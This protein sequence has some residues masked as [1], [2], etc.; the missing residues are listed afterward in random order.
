MDLTDEWTI[1]EPW[2]EEQRRPDGR[3]RPWRDAR[4]VPAER[5]SWESSRLRPPLRRSAWSDDRCARSEQ[6]LP[7]RP[8]HGG[9]NSDRGNRLVVEEIIW[10]FRTGR[11][12]CSCHGRGCVPAQSG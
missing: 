11:P 8:G 3:G 5:D 1:I 6:L 2:C 9:R 4:A 12:G 10:T 7:G